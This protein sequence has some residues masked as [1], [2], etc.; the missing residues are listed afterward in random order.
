MSDN[1]PM[2]LS[3]EEL[4]IVA[5]GAVAATDASNSQI[6]DEQASVVIIGANGGIASFNT[7][8]TAASQQKLQEIKFTGDEISGIPGGFFSV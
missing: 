5:G 8:K 3:A 6:L 2:E 1:K 4:D 7:Q